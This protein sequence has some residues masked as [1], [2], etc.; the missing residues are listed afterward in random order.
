MKK[1]TPIPTYES[2][3]KTIKESSSDN[4]QKNELIEFLD[5]WGINYTINDD[6]VIDVDGDVMFYD[7]DK[8]SSFKPIVKGKL[9]LKFGKVTGNFRCTHRSL[10]SLEGTPRM[11]G[12]GFVC[13]NNKITSLV[14]GPEEVGWLECQNTYIINL[15]GAPKTTS[16]N[17]DVSDNKRLENLE[18]SP[19]NVNNFWCQRGNL[20]N[21]S[22]APEKVD[23]NFYC[24]YNQLISFEGGPRIVGGDFNCDNNTKL[25]SLVGA[26]EKV[27]GDFS[28]S[29]NPSLKSFGGISKEIGGNLIIN[30]SRWLY[31]IT[32]IPSSIGGK[33]IYGRAKLDPSAIPIKEFVDK[34]KLHIHYTQ[35]AAKGN[36][37]GGISFDTKR[38]S[39]KFKS[40][41][42]IP[43]HYLLATFYIGDEEAM[44]DENGAESEYTQ[45]MDIN[46]LMSDYGDN[47]KFME[48]LNKFM[49]IY[50]ADI[51][52]VY[53]REKDIRLDLLDI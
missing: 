40:E 31:D 20:K 44:W 37:Y 12:G 51:S 47:K 53:P 16:G 45:S 24:G 39:K 25:V 6:L 43:G 26:P 15:V 49:E 38:R 5:S 1:I 23:G 30:D 10:T 21:L 2:F 50:P 3:K 33:V 28:C 4:P 36:I 14:G 41:T 48:I 27:G 46:Q 35:W 34:N 19:V 22:G 8:S 32:D 52:T 9:T 13:N 7:I 18:G 29:W 17:F 42:G 11:V